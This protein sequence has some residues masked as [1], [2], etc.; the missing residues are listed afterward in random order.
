[1]RLTIS[2]AEDLN[3]MVGFERGLIGKLIKVYHQTSVEED[4]FRELVRISLR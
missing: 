4:T 1:M 2:S 3:E